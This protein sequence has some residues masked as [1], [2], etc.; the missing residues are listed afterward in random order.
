MKCYGR[1]FH[2]ATG[3]CP[4]PVVAV[5]EN[6]YRSDGHTVQRLACNG[7]A[8]GNMKYCRN[9]WSRMTTERR[10]LRAYQPELDPA[11]KAEVA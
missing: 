1:A 8:T 6:V 2:P 4:E 10:P 11:N 9:T 3:E 5:I 7:H